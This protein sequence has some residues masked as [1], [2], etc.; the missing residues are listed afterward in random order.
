MNYKSIYENFINKRKNNTK[1]KG[2]QS[3]HILPRS[4]GGS[5][6]LENLVNL[7]VREH[8]HAHLLLWKI[9]RNREMSCAINM[10]FCGNKIKSSR[11]SSIALA[12]F[13]SKYA[14]KI[15]D[16]TGNRISIA[17][18][19]VTAKNVNT[20]ESCVVTTNEFYD[21]NSLVGITKGNKYNGVNSGFVTCRDLTTNSLVRVTQEEFKNTTTLVGVNKGKPG[22]WNSVNKNPNYVNPMKGKPGIPFYRNAC[23]QKPELIEVYKNCE[24]FYTA[25]LNRPHKTTRKGGPI[26]VA[27]LAGLPWHGSYR[28]VFDNITKG[29]TPDDDYRDFLKER[30]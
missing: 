7:T 5:N 2:T 1:S 17:L 27:R 22:C 30:L 29:W 9:H 24:L 8:Y 18:G 10:M 13:Y 16:D 23:N 28:M 6:D 4:M 26:A 12:E 14:F 25:Y 19:M 11:I 20:N 3:H 21:N 15:I